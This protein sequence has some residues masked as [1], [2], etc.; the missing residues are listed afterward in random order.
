MTNDT[1]TQVEAEGL[2]GVDF[3][4]APACDPDKLSDTPRLYVDD[5]GQQRLEL[6]GDDAEVF[7]YPVLERVDL[8]SAGVTL[9]GATVDGRQAIF[10]LPTPQDTPQDT[11][12]EVEAQIRHMRARQLSEPLST[13]AGDLGYTTECADDLIVG[14]MH[15]VKRDE[16]PASSA[17]MWKIGLEFVGDD[18]LSMRRAGYIYLLDAVL[19]V[20]GAAERALQ[21]M[22]AELVERDPALVLVGRDAFARAVND[23]LADPRTLDWMV[24]FV[25]KKLET[26]PGWWERHKANL[27]TA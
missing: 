17:V 14:L 21:A 13:Y 5:A 10:V 20:P 11:P 4:V 7:T 1:S 12:G 6:P 15:T 16:L 9:V 27:H 18:D 26:D 23:V 8:A 3:Y 2:Q 19:S 25:K 24:G 22:R